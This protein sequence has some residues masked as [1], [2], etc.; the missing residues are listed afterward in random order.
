MSFPLVA[1]MTWVPHRLGIAVG[2]AV[3]AVVLVLAGVVAERLPVPARRRAAWRVALDE[4]VP[5]GI[6][7]DSGRE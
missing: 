3:V 2:L 5:A 6:G 1:W 4:P 7:Q